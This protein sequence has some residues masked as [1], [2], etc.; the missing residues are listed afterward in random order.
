MGVG[1]GG[2]HGGEQAWGRGHEEECVSA[3]LVME[4]NGANW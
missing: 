1:G 2:I 4:G 3:A